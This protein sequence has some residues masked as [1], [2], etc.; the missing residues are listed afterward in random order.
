MKLQ[1]IASQG[2]K[3]P[4]CAVSCLSPKFGVGFKAEG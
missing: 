4:A 2:F 1:E 3:I